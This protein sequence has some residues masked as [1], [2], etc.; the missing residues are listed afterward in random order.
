MSIIDMDAEVPAGAVVVV[1]DV[2]RAFTT[3]AVAFESGA[4]DIACVSSVDAAREFRKRHPER[5]LAGETGG[6]KPPGFDFGNSPA[7]MAAARLD[8]RGLIQATSNGTRGLVRYPA[9]AAL[10]AASAVNAGATAR[11]IRKHHGEK[12]YALVCTGRTAEDLVCARHL[13][14]LLR[15]AEPERADL[16]AGIMAGAAEHA[17]FGIGKPAHERVDLSEDLR[18]CCDVDRV[19]FAMVGEI[20]DGCVALTREPT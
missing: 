8:G 12:P 20:R 11:W 1:I 2:I 5:L 13:D 16:V 10:L 18:F 19:G 14:G 17:R 15:G 3:A 4:A 9:A 6:L 7:E